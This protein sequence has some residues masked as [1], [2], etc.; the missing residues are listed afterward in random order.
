M[1]AVV[2]LA[3]PG[4]AQSAPSY[5]ILVFGPVDIV[6][7]DG[8]RVMV[9]SRKLLALLGFLS[10]RSDGAASREE[11]SEL[12]W[13]DRDAIQAR[14][15]LRQALRAMRVTP[16]AEGGEFLEADRT[17]VRLDR[18]RV[19]SDADA[20][21]DADQMNADS[22]PGLWRGAFMTGCEGLSARFDEWLRIERA[23]WEQLFL[24]SL[25][26]LLKA[27]EARGDE[28]RVLSIAQK[29]LVIDPSWESA[30]RALM[31]S[32]LRR[33]APATALRR[34]DS[35]RRF[36]AEEYQAH[37]AAETRALAERIRTGRGATE[38]AA[39]RTA[40]IPVPI[41]ARAAP[42]TQPT[43]VVLPFRNLTGD[44]GMDYLCEG[45]TDEVTLALSRIREFSVAARRTG[46]VLDERGEDFVAL[47]R[48]LDIAY[49]VNAAVRR[50]GQSLRIMVSI[51]NLMTSQQIWGEYFTFDVVSPELFDT[52]VVGILGALTPSVERDLLSM[53]RQQQPHRRQ[54]AYDLYLQGKQLIF[55]GLT[56][57]AASRCKRLLEDAVALDPGLAVA[58]NHLVRIYNTDTLE[59][60]AGGD[61]SVQ[62]ERA[63]RFAHK[64]LE[65]DPSDPHAYIS[66][67]WCHLW[68]RE[69]DAAMFQF[70]RALTLRPY[71]ADRL[72]DLATAFAMLGEHAEAENLMARA[73][74]M[75]P[76]HPEVYCMDLAE[77]RFLRRDYASARAL[78]QTLSLRNP[79][80]LFWEAACTGHLGERQAAAAAG[81][82]LIAAVR[83]IWVGD[84]AADEAAFVDW[85]MSHRPFRLAQDEENLREGLRRAG[86]SA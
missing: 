17:T 52:L 15:S 86:L 38:Q 3:A 25:D 82:A 37:P 69:F 80:R 63:M 6:A 10:L 71:D 59:T 68:R 32:D 26:S 22:L 72:T 18:R 28:G 20:F 57:E 36:L 53:P 24:G 34:Y 49:A 47:A 13:S 48:R 44:G 75:N 54:Q 29:L 83:A 77:I 41:E 33:S 61:L 65:L 43:V 46:A 7:P 12:L 45:L 55:K 30:H 81:Q 16:V 23:R 21:A 31:A 39:E 73:M 74:R 35:L 42:T 85:S 50:V 78:M 70:R 62:R 76:W 56:A 58:Y 67:G 51:S 27:A 14:G 11:V 2:P 40:S 4:P 64:G 66:L 19:A 60:E 79:R 84:P 1:S 8:G 5:S 9:R